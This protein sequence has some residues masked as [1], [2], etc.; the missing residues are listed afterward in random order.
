M[1][2]RPIRIPRGRECRLGQS[3]EQVNNSESIHANV[4]Q[5]QV[6]QTI[7][8]RHATRGHPAHRLTNDERSRNVSLARPTSQVE[9][10][11]CSCALVRSRSEGQETER[12][13]TLLS[14]HCESCTV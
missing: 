8:V 7:R 3:H 1:V 2:S 9:L 13:M 6:N 4:D 11:S 14:H 10:C 5:E 12:G